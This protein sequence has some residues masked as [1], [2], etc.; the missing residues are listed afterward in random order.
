VTKREVLSF[1]AESFGKTVTHGWLASFL[2][3]WSDHITRTVISLQEQLRLQIPRS[4][5]DDYIPLIQPYVPLVPTE[6]IFHLDE[7]GL[8]D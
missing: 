6:L 8:S 7:I 2:D 1:L 3:R 4:F 5:L